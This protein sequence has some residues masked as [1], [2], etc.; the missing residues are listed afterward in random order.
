MADTKI[1]NL[2]EKLSVDVDDEF[3]IVDSEVGDTKKVKVVNLPPSS[4]LIFQ[5]TSSDSGMNI[6]GGAL[7][8]WDVEHL[9]DSGY[10][11][12]SVASPSEIQFETAGRYLVYVSLSFTSSAER[13]NPGVKFKK[14]GTDVLDGE[15]LHGYI[16]AVDGHNESSSGFMRVIEV[17][18]DDYIEVTT[19]Q[20]AKSGTV[21]LRANQSILYI[22]KK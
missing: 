14:N 2:V 4:P 5:A 22:E 6:S 17:L 16:R 19:V 20:M 7:I 21:N 12:D 9:K 10:I 1:S 11:H 3:P 8:P 15:G 13:A 18:A